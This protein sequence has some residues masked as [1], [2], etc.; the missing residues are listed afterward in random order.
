MLV[1]VG[2][3]GKELLRVLTCKQFSGPKGPA[4][5]HQQLGKALEVRIRMDDAIYSHATAV[6]GRALATPL[7]HTVNVF[8]RPL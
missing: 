4:E 7:P 3:F 6:F 5:F 8:P 1:L 2:W